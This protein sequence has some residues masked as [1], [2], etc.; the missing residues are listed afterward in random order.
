MSAT[1]IQ[2][3]GS[4]VVAEDADEHF[5]LVGNQMLSFVVPGQPQG[6]GRARAGKR[7]TRVVLYTPAK[8][9]AYEGLIALAASQEMS[10]TG[11]PR[12]YGPV[13]IDLMIQCE[14]PASWSKKLRKAAFDGNLYPVTKP[15]LDN[16]L[17]AVCDGLNGVAFRD[18][19][20]IVNA[21]IRKRY[22]AE[23]CL[24][25]SVWPMV[26]PALEVA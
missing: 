12:F 1:M 16:V 18:D 4:A 2:T 9:V 21:S 13:A 11:G 15:D 8:T 3:I 20:Q 5:A 14:V 19:A 17:K 6:K 10:R 23:P 26:V 7:G 24:R 22:S 25:V